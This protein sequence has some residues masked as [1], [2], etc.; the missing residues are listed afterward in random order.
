MADPGWYPQDGQ[1]RWW[2]GHQWTANTAP[3]P[4]Q[5][6]PR[7]AAPAVTSPAKR[8]MPT[9]LKAGI[10]VVSGIVIVGAIGSAM[11][12]SSS[13]SSSATLITAGQ[14]SAAVK[15]SPTHASKAPASTKAAAPA[16]TKAVVYKKLT[17]RSWA[18]IAK[19]P[20]AH[21]SEAITVYGVVTQFD[22]A[23]GT[24]TFRADVDGV[25][26]SAYYDYPTNTI[27]TSDVGTLMDVVDGDIF[28]AKVLVLGSLS[29]DTS[30]GGS[31]TVPQLFVSS[32]KVIGHK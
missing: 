7:A 23:T 31:T 28:T 10:G 30:I 12:G 26:H 4:P 27:L 2:D 15:V 21:A 11:N 17:A 5:G 32:I 24:D 6:P 19:D 1:I 3:L 8:G 14:A 13:S 22:S 18:L 29:Y 20:N 9:A 16:P 25:K